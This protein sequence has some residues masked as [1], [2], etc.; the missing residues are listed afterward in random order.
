MPTSAIGTVIPAV[1]ATP[2]RATFCPTDA[3]ASLALTIATLI[4]SAARSTAFPILSVD[5]SRSCSVFLARALAAF[6]PLSNAA[7]RTL[8]VVTSEASS[9]CIRCPSVQMKRAPQSRRPDGL[10]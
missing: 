6:M 1:S 7:S 5:R 4:R 2:A 8:I 10:R 3:I 9:C